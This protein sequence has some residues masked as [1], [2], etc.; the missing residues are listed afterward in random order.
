MSI[1]CPSVRPSLKISETTKL[2]GFY[3]SGNIPTGPV[4][5]LGYIFGGWDTYNP[6]HFFFFAEDFL[7]PFFFLLK[8]IFLLPLG[9]KP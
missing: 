4:V 9:A 8:I 6:P 2:I 5:V 3:S 1:V 7:G